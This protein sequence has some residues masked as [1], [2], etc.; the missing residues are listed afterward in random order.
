[1]P[2][3]STPTTSVPGAHT[4]GPEVVCA[5]LLRPLHNPRLPNFGAHS[6]LG[7]SGALRTPQHFSQ[8]QGVRIAPSHLPAAATALTPKASGAMGLPDFPALCP[9]CPVLAHLCRPHRVHLTCSQRQETVPKSLCSTLTQDAVY[10]WKII[11][12]ALTP[13]SRFR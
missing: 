7:A 4:S 6:G 5:Y 1:M 12:G 10:F 9:P 8:S 2:R 3:P 11:P 13:A